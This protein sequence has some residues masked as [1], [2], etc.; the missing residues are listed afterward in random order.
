MAAQSEIHRLKITGLRLNV[1]DE[2]ALLEALAHALGVANE[3][4]NSVRI[5]RR[6][7]DARQRTLC[8][9]YSLAADVCLDQQELAQMLADSRVSL[10]Q[11]E[12]L[13]SPGPRLA[14]LSAATGRAPLALLQSAAA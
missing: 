4:I 6:S 10:L 11:D 7:L 3:R 2:S 14:A 12:P 8:Y 9:E 13:P 1:T 5:L